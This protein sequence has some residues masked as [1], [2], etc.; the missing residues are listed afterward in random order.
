MDDRLDVWAWALMTFFLFTFVA[1]RSLIPDTGVQAVLGLQIDFEEGLC[2]S[3]PCCP[4]HQ[5]TLGIAAIECQF[6]LSRFD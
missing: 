3:C 5:R 6:Q 1:I 2:Q 4:F